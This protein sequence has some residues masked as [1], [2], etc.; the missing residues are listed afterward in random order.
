MLSKSEPRDIRLA[1]ARLLGAIGWNDT[2]VTQALI[3]FVK[4]VRDTDLYEHGI[5]VLSWIAEAQEAVKA[6]LVDEAETMGQLQRRACSKDNVSDTRAV[7]RALE[8]VDSQGSQRLVQKLAANGG[9]LQDERWPKEASA[10][11]LRMG[12]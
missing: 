9:R 2:P 7:L 6:F 11:Y 1:A 5:V 12:M 4:D 10:V 8:G 3:A